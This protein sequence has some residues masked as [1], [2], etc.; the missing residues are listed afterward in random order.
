MIVHRFFKV[1]EVVQDVRRG[2]L[3]LKR[4]QIAEWQLSGFPTG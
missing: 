3:L 4:F 1:H 2:R